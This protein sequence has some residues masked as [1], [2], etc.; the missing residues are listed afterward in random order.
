MR[1]E[2]AEIPFPKQGETAKK[3]IRR[4]TVMKLSFQEYYNKVLGCFIGKNIGGTLGAPFEGF[5]GEYN[6]TWFMQD[7]SK[8]VPN[9][10][11]DLQLVWLRAIENE[12]ARVNSQI[13][14]E[15]W[16]T[17]ISATLCEYGAGKNNFNMGIVPPLSGEMRN[18]LRHSNGAWIRTE[19]WAC[20]CAGNPAL[21]ANYA[22][23]DSSVD[24]CGEGVYASVF[25][26]TMQAAAFFEKDILK[27]VE[28]ARS[29]L[30]QDCQVLRAVDCVLKAWEEKRTWKET[31]KLLFETTPCDFGK[32]HWEGTKDIPVSD[33]C[34]A[35]IDDP[36][37]PEAPKGF[38]A[39]WSIG[40][41]LI[42]L[43]WGEGDFGKS[44][45]ITTN[46]GEDT[47]C[48]A[49]TVG[50]IMGIILGAS[51][52]PEK[53]RKG[54]S[55][56]IATWTLR[57]DNGLKLPKT[58]EELTQRV[59]R[60]TPAILKDTCLLDYE[61]GTYEI[62]SSNFLEYNVKSFPHRGAIDVKTLLNEQGK[63]A[64]W[65]FEMLTVLVE[66]D[67]TLAA[68][69]AHQTKKFKLTFLNQLYTPQ[70][71]TV[72]IYN[73]PEDWSVNRG[74]EFCVG[75]EHWHGIGNRNGL[76]LEIT[77]G[78][79]TKGSYPFVLEISSNGRMTKYYVPITL[80]N[81]AC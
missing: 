18:E 32:W 23:F 4:C 24:H 9:D 59:V 63:T 43:L 27:L 46:L 68:V 78:E 41:I 69:S 45:C 66:Y 49:G 81:G 74:K 26:A 10:D 29:Y 25:T 72:K 55:N 15:Y 7:V 52:I 67:E 20:V 44:I 1:V 22:Y 37:I 70:Y 65:S 3:R 28:I 16:N 80:I 21:A 47:D 30:P 6:L 71:L 33:I 75:L 64:R 42:G 51:E 11:L 79:M 17:Y 76:E 38:D 13:L 57:I 77:A 73:L 31:R 40:A 2:K 50:S 36:Q 39:P 48:T 5:R 8:P 60:Q 54:C 58:V 35:Y 19:I 53:W 61:K 14:A 12:G 56:E 34:P 62:H